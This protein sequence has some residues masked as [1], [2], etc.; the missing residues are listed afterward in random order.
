MK[1][2]ATAGQAIFISICYVFLSIISVVGNAF[3]IAAVWK[4]PLKT[5]RFSP[6]NFTL[7]SLA[8]ADLLVGLVFAPA[9]ALLEICLGMSLRIGQWY[10]LLELIIMLSHFFQLTVSV[11][12]VVLLTIDRFFALA[13]PLKYKAIVTKKRVAIVSSSIWAFSFC[14]AVLSFIL[15]EHFLVLWFVH[16]LVIW[17][18]AEG[19]SLLYLITLKYLY[20]YHKKR[21]IDEISQ[22]NLVLLY[23]REMKV[24]M[25]ILSVIIVTL[26]LCYLPWLITQFILYF[27]EACH[28]REWMVSHDVATIFLFLNSALNPLLYAWRFAKFRATF[29]YFLKKSCL[30]KG[31]ARRKT[32]KITE[33]ISKKRQTYNTKL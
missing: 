17:L 32:I 21:T 2:D 28:V 24:F 22:S 4:D 19:S 13:K 26:Y 31:L 18:S 10:F 7:L 25:V 16:V 5:L 8:L 15:K 11:F 20:K 12:H 29:K 30:Q 14:Y 3:V 23:Q 6:S 1:S 9:A 27:C 33:N